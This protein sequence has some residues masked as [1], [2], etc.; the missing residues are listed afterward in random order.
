MVDRVLE[1]VVVMDGCFNV[2]GG[3]L[4]SGSCWEV[5]GDGFG[6][7]S[8]E[9]VEVVDWMRDVIEVDVFEVNFVYKFS[10][11]NVVF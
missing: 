11:L 2:G 6:K 4:V 10:S 5:R 8:V 7:G 1:I 9:S 3:E